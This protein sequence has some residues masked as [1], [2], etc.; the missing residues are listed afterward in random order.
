ML[1][2]AARKLLA[3][4][5]LARAQVGTLQVKLA[6]VAARVRE[7]HRRIYVQLTSSYPWRRL[8]TVFLQRLAEFGAT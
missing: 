2:Q 7:S 4:T 8:W 1:W 6:K 5:E 3:G